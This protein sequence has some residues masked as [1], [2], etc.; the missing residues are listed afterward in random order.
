M[1]ILAAYRTKENP[2][3]Q[4]SY[5]LYYYYNK[6]NYR[7]VALN[8]LNRAESLDSY[9]YRIYGKA[10][11]YDETGEFITRGERYLSNSYGFLVTVADWYDKHEQK[12]KAIKYYEQLLESSPREYSTYSHLGDIYRKEQNYDKAIKVWK[13]IFNAR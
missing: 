10:A 11:L 7:P 5:L 6:Y 13:E 2:N 1:D 3:A 9:D 8:Y 12:D 4:G